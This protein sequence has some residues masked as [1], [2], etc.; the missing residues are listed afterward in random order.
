M[1]KRQRRSEEWW[2]NHPQV[3]R[4]AASYKSNG[5]QCR[6]EAAPGANVC[7]QHGALAPQVQAAAAARIKMSVE[8]AVIRLHAMLDDPAVDARDKIKILHD[9][10]DRGGLG[11]TSKVLVGVA[12]VDPVEALFQSLLADP[13]ALG[14]ATPT[15]HVLSP[16][17]A[18]LNAGADPQ[19]AEADL[20]DVVD[21]EVVED[22]PHT[23]RVEES[24]SSRPPKHIRDALD[25]LI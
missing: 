1:A 23:V 20:G 2:A 7:N 25:R 14:P 9:L 22:D 4:C 6:M 19:E 18:A 11:A 15:E 13:N 21:A 10:L 16:E 12:E 8:D 24:M 17:I 3:M 5:Q